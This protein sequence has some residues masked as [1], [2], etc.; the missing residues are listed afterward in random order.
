MV[1]RQE[2]DIPLGAHEQYLC[3]V[4]WTEPLVDEE[5]AELLHCIEQGRVE[6]EK[7]TPDASILRTADRARTRL[8][9]GYQAL[10]VGL[11]KRY[12]RHCRTMELLD[13]VQEG[14]LGLLAAVE[15]YDRRLGVGSFRT[16]AF[17]W[18]RGMMLIALWQYEGAIRLPQERARAVRRLTMVHAQ[19]CTVLGREPTLEETAEEM[20]VRENVV[21]ELMVLR[22]QHVVSLYAFTDDDG[23]YSMEETIVDPTS[24]DVE[25]DI[26]DLLADALVMLPER[27]R[28]VINLRYGFEDG[29]SR[30]QKE[31]AYLLGVSAARVA[32]LDRQA[33]RRLRQLLSVA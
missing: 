28:L 10:L 4:R 12:V 7:Q 27:E 32:A 14:N 33:Q 3:G 17:S 19:L 5:E 26:C 20:G 31:V 16:W 21:R 11:A 22:E 23:D 6:Q 24:T 18:V 25:E 29:Q 15:K 8:I 13:L 30:T 1:S 9:E 2:Q